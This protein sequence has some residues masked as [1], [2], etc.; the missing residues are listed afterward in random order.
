[1]PQDDG[2]VDFYTP[3]QKRELLR[4]AFPSSK[5][6]A[7]SSFKETLAH[8]AGSVM[9]IGAWIVTALV[10]LVVGIAAVKWA[11]EELAK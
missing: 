7:W 4:E 6:S 2:D 8:T 9:L 3:E 1:M 5:P 11:I 10:V